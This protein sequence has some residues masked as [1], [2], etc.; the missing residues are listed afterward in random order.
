MTLTRGTRRPNLSLMFMTII[1]PCM[2]TA[3][4]AHAV[5]AALQLNK[6]MDCACRA[7]LLVD[8]TDQGHAQAR[9]LHDVHGGDLTLHA[10]D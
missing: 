9:R 5:C 2:A 8:D 1:S 7:A 4:Q 3:G 10:H 6:T